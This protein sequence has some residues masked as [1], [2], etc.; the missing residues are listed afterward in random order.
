M[1]EEQEGLIEEV[2]LC[3]SVHV[4]V[5]S[6]IFRTKM[7]K[8]R[9]NVYNYDDSP[10]GEIELSKIADLLLH[11]RY[12]VVR[13]QYVVDLIS[14][15]RFMDDKSQLGLKI[16]FPEYVEEV[17]RAVD[18]LT[19]NDLVGVLRGATERLSS[20]SNVKDIV[21]LT[22]NLYTLGGFVVEEGTPIAGGPLKR[23]LDGVATRIAKKSQPNPQ[24]GAVRHFQVTFR[25][26]R[27]QLEPDLNDKQIRVTIQVNGADEHLVLGYEEFFSELSKAH[28]HMSLMSSSLRDASRRPL[29][30]QP[31]PSRSKPKH[32]GP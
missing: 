13:D 15:Q 29:T 26:P 28:G 2:L 8:A 5:L 24:P 9:A 23:I 20:S 31:K 19:M 21:F 30:V 12:M 16:S 1:L 3:V 32:S 10:V 7:K 6:E 22:Q 25:S 14:D 18:G 4:R 11:Q 17:Q 27:F